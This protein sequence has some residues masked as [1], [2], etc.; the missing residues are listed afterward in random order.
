MSCVIFLEF[1]VLLKNKLNAKTPWCKSISVPSLH[2]KEFSLA[3]FKNGVF[4]LYI[5][6]NANFDFFMRA[7][8]ILLSKGKDSS[9]SPAEV[10]FIMRSY[11]FIS[12]LSQENASNPCV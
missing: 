10:V 5:T 8:R 2:T 3:C 11:E 4:L 7:F 6:S 1:N 12:T 9:L